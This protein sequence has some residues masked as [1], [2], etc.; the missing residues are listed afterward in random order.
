MNV[1]LLRFIWSRISR[2]RLP[3]M[4]RTSIPSPTTTQQVRPRSSTPTDKNGTPS[5]TSFWLSFQLSV[6]AEFVREAHRAIL[7]EM[8]IEQLREAADAI[9]RDYHLKQHLLSQ[10][11]RRV[12]EL[13]CRAALIDDVDENHLAAARGILQDLG[14]E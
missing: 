6:E 3:L 12:A 9:V 8:S 13:E 5:T 1:P 14:R 4:H 10:Y 11:V 2:A 7:R